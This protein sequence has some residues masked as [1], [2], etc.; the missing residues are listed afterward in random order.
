LRSVYFRQHSTISSGF[1]L[2]F[3]VMRWQLYHRLPRNNFFKYPGE[4]PQLCRFLAKISHH[5]YACENQEFSPN[6]S[7]LFDFLVKFSLLLYLSFFPFSTLTSSN[8]SSPAQM[9][10]K[11]HKFVN[12]KGFVK[13]A[14]QYQNFIKT[15][16]SDG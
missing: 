3:E 7:V 11:L 13:T 9:S 15:L 12:F 1:A 8:P 5:C 6:S 16:Y 2:H 4:L 14:D 10:Q